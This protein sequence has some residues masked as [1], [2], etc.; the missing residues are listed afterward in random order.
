MLD[1]RGLPRYCCRIAE[2]MQI[3]A[4]KSRVCFDQVEEL[5]PRT[6]FVGLKAVD[7]HN[8]L[9]VSWV[10]AVPC[11]EIFGPCGTSNRINL[12]DDRNSTERLQKLLPQIFSHRASP[13][14][15]P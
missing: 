4:C 13:E 9:L 2:T 1:V 5:P 11:S 14:G 8:Q 15:E 7:E 10:I 6:V 12:A 3:E